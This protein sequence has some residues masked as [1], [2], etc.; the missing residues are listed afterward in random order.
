MASFTA[1]LAVPLI[2]LTIGWRWAFIGTPIAFLI[3][4]SL[5]RGLESEQKPLEIKVEKENQRL[6]LLLIAIAT[7]LGVAAITSM[8]GFYVQSAVDRGTS[9]GTA[10]VFFAIGS[11]VA[12][13]ARI[14]WGWLVDQYDYSPLRVLT[15]LLVGGG[16]GFALLGLVESSTLLLIVTLT[17]FGVGWSWSGLVFLAA[18]QESPNAPATASGVVSAGSGIGGLTGPLLFGAVVE[19]W[20]YTPAWIMAS[21]W[22]ILGSITVSLIPR[23]QK[24]S[25]SDNYRN[26]NLV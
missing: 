23:I 9:V 20:S 16:I 11:L 26:R 21:L 5:T 7:G 14:F 22:L 25:Y 8:L 2:G 3:I 15:A 6:S 10:G 19:K 12:V 18:T 24:Y 13:P 17:C 1:G 4:F